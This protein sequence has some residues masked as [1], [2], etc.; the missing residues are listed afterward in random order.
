M[1]SFQLGKM[2]CQVKDFG[3]HVASC[4]GTLYWQ[5]FALSLTVTLLR[6]FWRNT[7]ACLNLA[8]QSIQIING[9]ERKRSNSLNIISLSVIVLNRSMLQTIPQ[10]IHFW[11]KRDRTIVSFFNKIKGMLFSEKWKQ[12]PLMTRA[13]TIYFKTPID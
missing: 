2:E 5:C 7:G 11:Y 1:W 4:F 8:T 12:Y 3:K 13:K 6:S 9:L 10:I